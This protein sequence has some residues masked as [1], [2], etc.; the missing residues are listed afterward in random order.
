[1]IDEIKALA[2]IAERM[3]SEDTLKQLIGLG[4]SLAD[5]APRLGDMPT[6]ETLQDLNRTL[7][8]FGPGLRLLTENPNT[9]QDLRSLAQA[10][11][12]LTRTL[13]MLGDAMPYLKSLS[14]LSEY[15]PYLKNLPSDETMR[16]GLAMLPPPEEL[17]KILAGVSDLIAFAKMLK[18]DTAKVPA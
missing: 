14:A 12:I 2:K 8:Q 6:N 11:P 5:L 10:M 1:M 9:M 13:P 3:P 7:N 4:G 15:L 18:E 17:K 16:K